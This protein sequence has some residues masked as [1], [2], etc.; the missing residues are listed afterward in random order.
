[1]KTL[2]LLFAVSMVIACGED[3]Q[4]NVVVTEET[5]ATEETKEEKKKG[6]SKTTKEVTTTTV[7][8]EGAEVTEEEVEAVVETAQTVVA[9]ATQPATVANDN[10]AFK[11]SSDECIDPDL[12]KL[13]TGVKLMLCN[14]TI[15]QGTYS[16][17]VAESHKNCSSYGEIGCITTESNKSTDLTGLVS[18]NIRKGIT[19]GGVTGTLV[20][21]THDLSNLKAENIKENITIDGVTGTVR[22]EGHTE[23][24]ANGESGCVATTTYKATDNTNLTAENIRSGTVIAGITGQYPSSTYPLN[25]SDNTADLDSAT[26]NAKIKSSANFEWFSSDGTRYTQAGDADITA[27]NIK[28][29]I[30][31]FGATGTVDEFALPSATDL[32]IGTTV[33]SV[34]GTMK[35]DCRNAGKLS[36]YDAPSL[37]DNSTTG[38]TANSAMNWW[39]TF[40]DYGNNTG[41]PTAQPS[42][43]SSNNLCGSEMWE[44]ATQDGTCNQTNECIFKDK[45]TN[46]QW[47]YQVHSS[48]A[49]NDAVSDCDG[50][51]LGGNTDWRLPTQKE[52]MVA[53]AHGIATKQDSNWIP[54]MNQGF[55]SASHQSQ[56]ISSARKSWMVVL[57]QGLT[58]TYSKTTNGRVI[59]VR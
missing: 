34:T 11:L 16:P 49:W 52:L 27:G 1:M 46:L 29:D 39:D 8:V 36:V 37:P 55:W 21:D 13:H 35:T 23:C 30:T 20:E 22:P 6:K 40:E 31:I 43:W 28:K 9:E 42:G 53:Y 56:I 18:A 59:C 10:R 44:D 2:T 26:F 47:S 24:T 14:G 12:T 17:P 58:N 48:R 50:L 57:E 54:D 19:I 4:V 45:T 38:G 32:R 5:E 51:S 3:G 7:E 15:A 41:I 25:G 33:G